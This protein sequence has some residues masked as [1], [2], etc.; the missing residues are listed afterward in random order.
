MIRGLIFLFFIDMRPYT[1]KSKHLVE[2]IKSYSKLKN[3]HLRNR[4]DSIA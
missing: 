2:G 1:Q 4:T 3:S